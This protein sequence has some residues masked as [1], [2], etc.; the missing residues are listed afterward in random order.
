LDEA[1]L[2]GLPLTPEVLAHRL[3]QEAICLGAFK[4]GRMIGAI[5]LCLDGYEEDE[6]RAQF[7]PLPKGSA[8]WDFDVY[9]APDHRGG[10]GFLR[11]WDEANAYLRARGVAWSLS[12]ISAFNWAS[13]GSHQ[14]LSAQRLGRALFVRLGGWQI[15]FA[16][17]RPHVYFSIGKN[18]RPV[19][20]IVAPEPP[21]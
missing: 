11:L 9:V 12:R 19:F 15:S 7:V 14:R 4:A 3:E 8:A 17:C 10:L 21:Q 16:T 6:V 13:L 1:L 2:L 20:R 5:W 18:K